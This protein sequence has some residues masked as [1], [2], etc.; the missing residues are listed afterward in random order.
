[1]EPSPLLT[2]SFG[3]LVAGG[4]AV[5]GFFAIEAIDNRKRAPKDFLPPAE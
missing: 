2:F 4:V 1:M 5:L 3:L